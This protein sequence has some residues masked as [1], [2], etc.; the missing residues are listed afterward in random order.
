MNGVEQNEVKRREKYDN[1][2]VFRCMEKTGRGDRG[3]FVSVS[4]HQ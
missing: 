1:M 4:V 2:F 3:E